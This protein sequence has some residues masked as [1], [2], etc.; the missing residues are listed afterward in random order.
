MDMEDLVQIQWTYQPDDFIVDHYES[1]RG[2]YRIVIENGKAIGILAGSILDNGDV[3]PEI[4]R[5]EIL[6]ILDGFS[7][8]RHQRYIFNS[9]YSFIRERPDGTKDIALSVQAAQSIS[10]AGTVDLKVFDS[11]GKLISDTRAQR[12][13]DGK[14]VADLLAGHHDADQ[15]IEALKSS[16][17]RSIHHPDNEF[18]YLYELTETIQSKFT[19]IPNAAKALGIQENRV[20]RLRQLANDHSLLEGRHRGKFIGQQRHATENELTEA[21]EIAREIIKAYLQYLENQN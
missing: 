18:V 9:S 3:S 6:I 16:Y 17:V 8:V 15:T 10:L 7:I 12:F 14:K 20:N 5:N 2:K 4:I 19:G 1:D 13:E 21:R 11:K